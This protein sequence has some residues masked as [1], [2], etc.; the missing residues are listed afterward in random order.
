[1]CVQY[2][3]SHQ[4][5]LSII[6]DILSITDCC[7]SLT[8]EKILLLIGNFHSLSPLDYLQNKQI[9]EYMPQMW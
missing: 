1:M 7:A 6:W 9:C 2:E 5:V 3:V 4:L 8:Y